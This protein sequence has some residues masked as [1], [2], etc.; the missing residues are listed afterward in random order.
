MARKKAKW[1]VVG[2]MFGTDVNVLVPDDVRITVG[3]GLASNPIKAMDTK[4][5]GG[6][7]FR[8]PKA[9]PEDISDIWATLGHF[10]GPHRVWVEWE[11]KE[12]KVELTAFVRIEDKG[13]ATMF[14]FSHSS[15]EKWGDDKEREDAKARKRKPPKIRVGKDGRITARVTVETL[16]D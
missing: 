2:D 15:F 5:K 8:N 12:D 16:G 11:R 10:S 13:E 3:H 7:L 6:Y 4:L 14:A 1:E 9:K